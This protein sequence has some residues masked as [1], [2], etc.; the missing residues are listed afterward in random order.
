L[1]THSIIHRYI[2]GKMFSDRDPAAVDEDEDDENDDSP[3]SSSGPASLSF[4]PS[5]TPSPLL[6]IGVTPRELM[7]KKLRKMAEGLCE[8]LDDVGLISFIAMNVQD[9]EVSRL[10]LPPSARPIPSSFR[11]L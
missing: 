2:D 6:R 9:G 3:V 8:V 7:G 5:P 1:R 11:R 4:P 10:S